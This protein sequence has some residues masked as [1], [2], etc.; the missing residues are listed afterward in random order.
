MAKKMKILAAIFTAAFVAFVVAYQFHKNDLILTMGITFGTFSYHFLMRLAV[1]TIVD[2]LFHNRMDYTKWWF[3]PRGFEK[4]LYEL[5]KVK[6]WKKDI[7][8][9]DPDTFRQRSIPLRNSRR[10]PAR[11]RSYTKLS[12][13]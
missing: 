9:Y 7:P 3:R 8:T 4:K 10:R 1:G 5:L 6:K 11:R 13:F 2:Y 12:W